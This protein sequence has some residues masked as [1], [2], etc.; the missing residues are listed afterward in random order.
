MSADP[1]IYCLQQLTDYRQFERLCSDVMAGSGYTNIDPL[2]GSSDAGETRAHVSRN[3]PDDVAIFAYSVRSDWRPKLFE[4]CERIREEQH[5]LQRLVFVCTGT[6][7]ASQK[8]TV[9]GEVRERFGWALEL[10]DIERLRVRLASDLRHLIAQ[11]PSI[12]CPPWFPVRGGLSISE[13]RDILV[14]DHVSSDHAL[15]TWLARRLQVS[16]YRTWCYGTAPLAGESADESVRLLVEKRAAVYLPVLSSAAI[17]NADLMGRCGLACNTPEL[18]V[19]CWSTEV[20]SSSLT[21][22]MRGLTPV[23][24]DRRWS[25]GLSGLLDTLQA[26]GI[27]ADLDRLRGTAIAIRSYVP[28][29]VTKPMPERSMQMYSE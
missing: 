13:S 3:N 18:M 23:H 4:D 5:N 9:K 19:P 15:A 28:E 17:Q 16:G 20:D 10:F 29:P 6:V 24:F 27:V 7:T 8:D 2:G 21:T 14:I 25:E 11:H 1:I 26:R 22:K 12:F